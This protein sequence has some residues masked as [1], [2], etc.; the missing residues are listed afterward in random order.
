MLYDYVC[1]D[2]GQKFE[3]LI[4]K[5]GAGIKTECPA[6][7]SKDTQNQLSVFTP[8]DDRDVSSTIGSTCCCSTKG[9]STCS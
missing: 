9:R 6:C 7:T 4:R 1:Y 8:L 3:I 5:S 2:C